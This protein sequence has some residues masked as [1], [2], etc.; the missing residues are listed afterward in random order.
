[1]SG[2]LI[3]AVVGAVLGI[4]HGVILWAG[5]ATF[6]SVVTLWKYQVYTLALTVVAVVDISIILIVISAIWW[7]PRLMRFIEE[8]VPVAGEE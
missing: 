6:S 3:Y 4:I 7:F 1:M 2:K 5:I 8:Y